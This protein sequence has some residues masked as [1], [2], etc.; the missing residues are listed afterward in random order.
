MM[1]LGRSAVFGG[2]LYVES[3]YPQYPV[4]MQVQQSK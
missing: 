2:R 4:R 3:T 1:G